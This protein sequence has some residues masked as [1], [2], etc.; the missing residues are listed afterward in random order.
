LPGRGDTR[1]GSRCRLDLF[2]PKSKH[3]EALQ[4]GGKMNGGRRHADAA[5]GLV[6]VIIIYLSM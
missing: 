4:V 1:D 6:T 5:F 3:A 2:A